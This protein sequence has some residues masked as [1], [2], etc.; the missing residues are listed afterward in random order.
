MPVLE[1]KG[2]DQD[3]D[4]HPHA[5]DSVEKQGKYERTCTPRSPQ[6]YEGRPTPH[7][8]QYDQAY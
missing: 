8:R 7:L 3:N 2:V 1:E 4:L 5:E 6:S